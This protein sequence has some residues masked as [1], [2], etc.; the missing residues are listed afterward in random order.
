MYLR[1]LLLAVIEGG[2]VVE[3][4]RRGLLVRHRRPSAGRR[5]VGKLATLLASYGEVA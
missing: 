3:R 5:F 2:F 1:S 4:R